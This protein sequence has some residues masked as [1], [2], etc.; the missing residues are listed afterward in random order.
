MF[1]HIFIPLTIP[2]FIY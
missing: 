2:D 1:V